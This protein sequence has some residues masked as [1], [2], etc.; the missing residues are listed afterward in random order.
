MMKTKFSLL[1]FALLFV[2][3]GMMAQD[4]ITIGVI[5]YD[6]GDVDKSFKDL[7]DQGFGSC[8]LNYQKNKFTKDFAEKVKAASKKH[9]I[10]VTTVVGVPGSHC[11]WN[12][13]QGPATIG[14]VPKE[15]RAEKIKVYHEMIDF[16]A[17]AEIS[18]LCTLIS[19][20]YRKIPLPNNIKIL[21]RS[22]RIWRIMPSSA[23]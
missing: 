17:M 12:F 20:L 11:V 5:Q 22:C 16:C 8:E 21:S 18:P 13:R 9:N 19:V 2:C 4:K 23:V 10:K 14:L 7:H 15:E 1:I 3:S 6:L